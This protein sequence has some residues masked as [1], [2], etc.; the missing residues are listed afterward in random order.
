M[1][2]DHIA[3]A[4]KDLQSSIEL[5]ST[6]LD[7]DGADGV[8]EVPSEKVKVAFFQVGES[9]FELLGSTDPSGPIARFLEKRGPGIH[10]VCLKVTDIKAEIARYQEK[11]FQFVGEA[12]RMGAGGHMVAFIHPKSTGG[13][14]IELAQH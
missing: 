10:H 7:K 13:V 9:R 8:E 6:L 5:Y 11:G 1:E 12:P 2:I 3:I 4:V 14:L